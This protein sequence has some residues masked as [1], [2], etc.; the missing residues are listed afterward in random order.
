MLENWCYDPKSLKQISA[1]FETGEPIPDE[2]I[3]RIVKAKNVDAATQNL[4]QLFFGIF[5]MTL[6]TSEGNDIKA[7]AYRNTHVLTMNRRKP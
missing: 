6:H 7:L 2:I 5:D 1:H 4:R 3:Q